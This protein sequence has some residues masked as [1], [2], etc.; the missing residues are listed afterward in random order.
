MWAFVIDWEK[1]AKSDPTSTFTKNTRVVSDM[2]YDETRMR[3]WVL[4]DSARH[5]SEKLFMAAA[6]IHM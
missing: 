3:L 5:H 2:P 6:N 4:A 1:L